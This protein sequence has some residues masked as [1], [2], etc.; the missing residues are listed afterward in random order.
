MIDKSNYT[1]IEI[2]D[3]LDDVV[4][5]AISEGK[6]LYRK[7]KI[8]KALKRAS[9]VAAV[10]VVCVISLLNISPVFAHAAYMV[11]V[12]GDL[13]RVV[14]FREFHVEDEIK[15]IDAKIPQ[16]ENT[17]KSDLEKRVNLEIQKVI[18]ECIQENEVVA[19]EYYEAFIE[20]GGKPEEFIPVGI[21]VD[22][23][24]KCI[25]DRYA[26]FVVSQ[27]ETAFNAYNHE[28]YYNID[29]ESG[30]IFTLK[31]WYG[32]DYRQMVSESIENT[33][34]GWSDEQKDILWDDIAIIDLISENTDFYI[35]QDNQVVVVFPKYEVAYGAAGALEFTIQGADD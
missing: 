30:R 24:I 32:N 8:I 25:N 34:A 17:G 10:F 15:Y 13:C 14:T 26:S 2:P 6:S 11:P 35:N 12:I 33:I 16:I 3:E 22:Y 21:T 18:N 27:Y 19:K 23:E 1:N 28:F 9:A 4:N 5:A 29:L 31:E 20:T 7:N